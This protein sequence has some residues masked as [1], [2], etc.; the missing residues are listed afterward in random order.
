MLHGSLIGQVTSTP[1]VL[2]S[3]GG[4]SFSISVGSSMLDVL[5]THELANKARRQAVPEC[6]VFVQVGHVEDG[7]LVATAFELVTPGSN[8]LNV[9]NVAGRVSNWPEERRG[10]LRV[11]LNVEALDVPTAIDLT[12]PQHRQWL[13]SL[14]IEHRV[15]VIGALSR[16]E[17]HLVMAATRVERVLNA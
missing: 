6:F 14:Q 8:P 9:F 1:Q 10:E 12:A 15:Q 2:M 3:P 7:R 17:G 5:V 16:A 13:G 4:L 11:W